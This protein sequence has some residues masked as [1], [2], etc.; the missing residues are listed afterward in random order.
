MSDTSDILDSLAE[1]VEKVD[2]V[3]FADL[4]K[5]GIGAGALALAFRQFKLPPPSRYSQLS[6][7]MDYAKSLAHSVTKKEQIT[8]VVGLLNVCARVLSSVSEFSDLA[9]QISKV[10]Q[11]DRFEDFV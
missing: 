9:Y 5:V 4:A 11:S 6:S 10:V 8:A 1:S 3:S 2:E 7:A